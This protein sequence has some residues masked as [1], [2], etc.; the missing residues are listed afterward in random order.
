VS[1]RPAAW[2]CAIASLLAA[3]TPAA[4]AEPYLAIQ[5]G[6]KCNECHVNPTGGGLRNAFGAVFT[7]NVLAQNPLPEGFPVWTGS[8]FKFLQLG[9]DARWDI[10]RTEVP[11]AP[12]TRQSGFEQ[13]RAYGNL[14]LI[15]DRLTYYLDEQLAPGNAT[16]I[17]YYGRYND[18]K[19]GWYVKGGQFYVPF[20]WR[21][22]DNTSFVR[23]VSGIS[24]TTPDRGIELGLERPGWSAQLDYTRGEANIAL[25]TGHEITG[26]VV[27][28]WSQW[29]V[30]AAASFTESDLGNR[31][32]EGL[33][34]GARSGAVDWLGELDFVRDAGYPGS[35]RRLIGGL[36]EAN[37][38]FRKGQNLKITAEYF[39]PDLSVANDQQTRWSLVYEYTPI[40]FFQLRAGY[41]RYR[42]IPQNDLENRRLLFLE[43]HAFL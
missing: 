22:Q 37:W 21:L 40:P 8:V 20:G 16:P 33:F 5:Q 7:E 13:I 31:Q 30:G 26:Q 28:V 35:A 17:E 15:P 10:S 6:Y 42:G 11:D 19:Y 23:E 1:V 25:S 9:A 27:R 12:T 24:M 43:L 2:L 34:V 18:P 38:G 29:R 36:G 14:I 4:D 3:V 39:D 32:V 41:R